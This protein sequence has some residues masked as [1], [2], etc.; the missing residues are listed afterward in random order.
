MTK[1]P[2]KPKPQVGGHANDETTAAGNTLL[3]F[4]ANSAT[5]ATLS[6]PATAGT[7][8]VIDFACQ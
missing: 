7:T 8:D 1:P 4:S 3:Y 5:T 6:V 2:K